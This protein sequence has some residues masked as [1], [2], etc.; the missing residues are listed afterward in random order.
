MSA[1]NGHGFHVPD[2]L[3]PEE[4]QELENIRRRKQELLED[5]QIKQGFSTLLDPRCTMGADFVYVGAKGTAAFAWNSRPFVGA[6]QGP[7][8]PRPRQAP[9]GRPGTWLTA[10]TQQGFWKPAERRGLIQPLL[11]WF[12]GMLT[13]ESPL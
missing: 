11:Y 8:P 7:F 6:G 2:D 5:I 4:H 13:A 1:G 10:M 12:G 3:T 9:E